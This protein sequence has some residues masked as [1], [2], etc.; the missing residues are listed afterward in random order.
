MPLASYRGWS[1]LDLSNPVIEKSASLDLT[2]AS[3]IRLSNPG[4]ES[5]LDTYQNGGLARV[6]CSDLASPLFRLGSEKKKNKKKGHC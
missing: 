2:R 4:V 1:H 5:G 3:R 6:P